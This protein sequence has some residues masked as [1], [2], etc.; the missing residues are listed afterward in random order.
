MYIYIFIPYYI[1]LDP[2]QLAISTL[3]YLSISVA[4]WLHL[5]LEHREAGRQMKMNVIAERC[6]GCHDA[7]L[8]MSLGIVLTNILGIIIE[9]NPY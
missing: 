5:G 4:F 9:W 8:L 2:Q 7:L 6:R 1:P 3:F